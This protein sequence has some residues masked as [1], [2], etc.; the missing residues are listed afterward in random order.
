MPQNPPYI[1]NGDADAVNWASNFSTELTAAP[2]DYGL[3]AGN[4]V[5]VA[6]VVD[7]FV[8]AFA[9][10]TNPATRTPVTIAAK[11]AARAAMESTV[12]P[13]ATQIASNG[14]VSAGLKTTIGVTNR[15]TTKTRNAVTANEIVFEVSYSAGGIAQ[16]RSQDPA[17]PLSKKRPLGATGWQI[18]VRG[19][20]AGDPGWTAVTGITATRP[21]QPLDPTTFAVQYE[22][23]QIRMRWQGAALP[24]GGVNVGPWSAW[25]DIVL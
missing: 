4:A 22:Q 21:I 1:P 6:A 7:P 9:A 17:T 18:E 12:R 23:Y 11:D 5:T 3:V 16:I 10:A 25:T 8:A 24:G 20:N 15:V 13:F 2:T 14:S 19:K